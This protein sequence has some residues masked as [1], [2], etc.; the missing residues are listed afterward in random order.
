[1]LCSHSDG[2]DNDSEETTVLQDRTYIE[3]MK[4]DILRRA[5]EVSDEEEDEEDLDYLGNGGGKPKVIALAFD[6]EDSD[7]GRVKVAGD[8]EE[9]DEDGDGE[10]GEEGGGTPRQTPETILELAY[11]RDPKLFDRDAQTRRSKQRADLKAQTSTS[12]LPF[13]NVNGTDVSYFQVG[14][15]SKSKDGGLCWSETSVACSRS[16]RITP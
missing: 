2:H 10:E 3:Q 15:T 14:R 13:H 8:G 1:M 4:A 6:E 11:I 12:S 5:E 16:S 7:A 9:S